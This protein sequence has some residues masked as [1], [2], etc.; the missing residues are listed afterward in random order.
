L[1]HTRLNT[2]EVLI[3]TFKQST[4]T[5]QEITKRDGE[6]GTEEQKAPEP[7]VRH[8][9]VRPIKVPKS[10]KPTTLVPDPSGFFTVDLNPTPIEEL[11]K[12]KPK[13]EKL[14]TEQPNIATKAVRK[15]KR[16]VEP[17]QSRGETTT[18]H[19]PQRKKV[20]NIHEKAVPPRPTVEDEE[21]I[22][23]DDKDDS[24]AKSVA[25]R[26]KAKEE[27]RKA[28]ANKKRKREESGEPTEAVK[29]PKD[30][31]H[32]EKHSSRV[33]ELA[34]TAPSEAPTPAN[35]RQGQKQ[36]DKRGF[37]ETDLQEDHENNGDVNG[38]SSR[39]R[40]KPK[41]KRAKAQ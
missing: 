30:K 41:S 26:T 9:P 17:H 22:E 18:E 8:V 23:E 1:V 28:K 39:K 31:K 36:K 33:D 25:A 4:E 24:F 29:S 13:K 40:K 7:E 14:N 19:E 35:E 2:T 38:D 12:E 15:Q 3:A 10:Q 27:K 5:L 16:N 6:F 32:K 11:Y 37:A 20:K 34:K 21:E